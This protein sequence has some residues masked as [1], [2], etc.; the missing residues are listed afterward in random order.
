[1]LTRRVERLERAGWLSEAARLVLGTFFVSSGLFNLVVS[2]STGHEVVR[3]F[4][5]MA[6]P[7]FDAI[8]RVAVHPVAPVA[9]LAVGSFQVAAGVLTLG[10][11]SRVHVGLAACAAWFVAIVPFCGLCGLV[12]VACAIGMV[13]LFGRR[14]DW[15]AHEILTS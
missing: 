8:L 9:L 5:G 2:A 13:P 6:L 14:Y 4:E 15:S 10:R 7:G 1:M 3:S 12:N 11:G